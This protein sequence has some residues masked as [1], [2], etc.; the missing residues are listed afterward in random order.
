LR[1]FDALMAVVRS[2]GPFDAG[3]VVVAAAGNESK[4]QVDPRYRIAASLP[5]A[6]EG[7]VS[8]GALAMV[9]G[10]LSI[11]PFS[12]SMPV[13]SAPGVNIISA[14]AGGR[15][16]EDALIPFSGTSMATPHVAGAAALWFQKLGTG[17]GQRSGSAVVANLTTNARTT[18]FTTATSVDDLGFGL[19]TVPLA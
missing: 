13:I 3:T 9:G 1:L 10:S 16:Q 18:N 15:K 12:N 19:A 17:L 4:R 2:R 8:V 7:V 14:R 5:A 6:A 11:A